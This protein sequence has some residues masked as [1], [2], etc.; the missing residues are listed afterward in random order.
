MANRETRRKQKINNEKKIITSFDNEGVPSIV[1]VTILVAVILIGFYFLTMYL[2][3]NLKL[4]SKNNNTTTDNTTN[5]TPATIQYDEILAGETFNMNYSEY[6]V[7]FYDFDD[8]TGAIYKA[9]VTNFKTA[10]SGSKIYTVDLSKSIND[11]YTG[12]TSNPKANKIEDLKIKGAT[13]IKIKDGSN[14]SYVEGKDA[15]NNALN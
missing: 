12:E 9:M 6:Y 1:K 11:T 14:V 15:I 10:H 8:S 7:L 5:T 13:L 4:G 3:G 2:T